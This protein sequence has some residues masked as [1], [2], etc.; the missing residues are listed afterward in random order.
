MTRSHEW[1]WRSSWMASRHLLPRFWS[2]KGT[3][4]HKR[5]WPSSSHHI[6][7]LRYMRR[8]ASRT[9]TKLWLSSLNREA[10]MQNLLLARWW[11]KSDGQWTRL[12]T[13]LSLFT[14]KKLYEEQF[15]TTCTG[16]WKFK[17]QRK[18]T[19]LSQKKRLQYDIKFDYN[20]KM[21]SC[22]EKPQN[23]SYHTCVMMAAKYA[24]PCS[25]WCPVSHTDVGALQ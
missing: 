15:Q 13:T 20:G 8:R 23:C 25:S 21:L 10:N 19:A 17:L 4:C 3:W 9:R 5:A 22:D 16:S 18:K 2:H 7:T 1:S 24:C 12:L 6:C 14:V 11:Q